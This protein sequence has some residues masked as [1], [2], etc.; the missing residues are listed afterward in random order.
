MPTHRFIGLLLAIA[1][2]SAPVHAA[3]QPDKAPRRVY[4]LHDGF[5]TIL[6]YPQPNWATTDMKRFL[7]RHG[8]DEADIV[9]LPCPFPKASLADMFPKAGFEFFLDCFNPASKASQQS[10]LSLHQA[11]SDH[12]VRVTDKLVWVGHSAGGQIGMT[13]AHLGGCLAKYPDLAKQAGPHPFDMVVTLGSPLG[14]HNDQVP[15][16]VKRRHYYSPADRVVHLAWVAG[17]LALPLLGYQNYRIELVPVPAPF[18]ADTVVR[19]FR[20]IE[21]PLW[22]KDE[23]VLMR[24]LNEHRRDY[25]P[26]WRSGGIS[27]T[28]GPSLAGFMC[29]ALE[30]QGRYSFEDAFDEK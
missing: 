18:S 27:P 8:I 16:G 15:A 29:R 28:L 11:L 30:E 2:P 22:T 17:N 19:V 23:H 4:V 9:Q 10:Y 3:Q 12:G 13:M 25:Q 24:I 5:H 1:L 7:L 20:G 26:A 6:S 21:H 14:L